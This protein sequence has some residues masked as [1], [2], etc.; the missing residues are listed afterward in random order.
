MAVAVVTGAASGIGNASARRL[1]LGMRAA[2]P[3]LH[4]SDRGAI[5]VTASVSGLFADPM[6]WAYN[7]TKGGVVNL[8]RAAAFDLGPE[9][10]RVNGVCPSLIRGT[11]MT[12]PMETM[13]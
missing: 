2:I 11:G 13:A 8:V 4:R 10:I 7:A 12:G 1:A 9:G 5:V 3:A 6:M